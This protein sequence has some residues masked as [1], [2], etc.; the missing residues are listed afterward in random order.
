MREEYEVFGVD[1]ASRG[2]R[3]DEAIEI[4]RGAWKGEMFEFHG[5]HF[6]F[7]RLVVKPSPAAPIPIWIGGTSGAALRR[8]GRVADGWMGGGGSLEEVVECLE[9]VEA[10]RIEAGRG[11][12]DFETM[13]LHGVGLEKNFDDVRRL[14][15]AGLCGVVHLPFRAT[16]GRRSTLDAKRAYLDRFAEDVMTTI[17]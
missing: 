13:T 15:Q 7:D 1:F 8:A 9:R 6:D 3:L 11:A 14:E 4:L 17:G 5:K 10:L 2:R 12:L 16:L